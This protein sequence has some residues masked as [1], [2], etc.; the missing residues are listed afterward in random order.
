MSIG[1]LDIKTI[2][3]PLVGFGGDVLHPMGKVELT[4]SLGAHPRRA[5]NKLKFLVL[6]APSPYSAILGHPGLN[7]FQAIASTY[8]MKLKFPSPKGVG[9]VLGDN[10][11]ARECYSTTLRGV[12]QPDHAN[13]KG[14]GDDT[15][16]YAKRKWVHAIEDDNTTVLVSIK[17]DSNRLAA[18]EELKTIDLVPG[19]S[20][21]VLRIGSDL[22]PNFEQELSNLIWL[23]ADVFAW[24]A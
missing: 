3:T 1:G 14:K 8:H 6:D 7:C 18:V 24:K 2:R 10:R 11:A 20:M 15:P 22:D 5:T 19:D 13:K 16:K 12:D 4:F 23:N 9:E 21:M 17:D